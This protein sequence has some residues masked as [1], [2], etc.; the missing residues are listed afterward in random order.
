[1]TP[2]LSPELAFDPKAAPPDWPAVFGRTAPLTVEIGT[3][4]G[5]YLADEAARRPDQDFVGVE[6]SGE[7]FVKMRK[8]IERAGLSNVR[9]VRADAN[10]VLDRWFARESLARIVGNHSDPWPKRRHRDRRLFRPEFYPLAERLLAPGG[11]LE[12]QT[13]VGWYFNLAINALRRRSGWRIEWA[14]AAEPP[15]AEAGE[16][17]TNFERKALAAG[18]TLWG[19]RARRE[20]PAREGSGIQA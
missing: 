3:G 14:G 8:R 17:V 16:V 20:E 15:K 6:I 18:S 10:L 1:M 7:F 9:C 19:Y 2:V 12:F 4:N 13:D 11:V 5:L